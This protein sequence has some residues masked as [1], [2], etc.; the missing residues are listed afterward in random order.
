MKFLIA[1]FG[2]IGRRHLRNLLSLGEKDIILYRSNHSTLPV[3]EI[4]EFPVET[5]IDAAFSHKPDAVIVSN[6]T[7]LHLEVALQAA[8]HGCHILLEK[9][10]S[11][12]LA[13]INEFKALVDQNTIQVL[14]GFQWRFHPCFQQ[15]AKLISGGTIGRP[16]SASTHYGDYIPNWHPWE[17]YRNS[18]AA[19]RNMG[20][21]VVRTL[22]HP[23]DYTRWLMG[24]VKSVWGVTGHVSDLDID[25]EDFADV[26]FKHSNQAIS[27]IHLDYY[28]QPSSMRLEIIGTSGTIAWDNADNILR[29]FDPTT[30]KWELHP[31]PEKF[32]RNDMFLE[33]MCHFRAV[34]RGDAQPICSLEDGIAVQNIIASIDLASEENVM[35]DL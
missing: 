33:E 24:E 16:L 32:E 27:S 22:C 8:E 12:S 30:G 11:H 18:Y 9:P 7:H 10:V 19:R 35:V 6:P 2:S 28:Q 29:N 5:N 26:G 17:D 1:G 20:G 31:A 25:A 23:L 15:A 14:V 21:G 13:R 34:A 3:D 4:A